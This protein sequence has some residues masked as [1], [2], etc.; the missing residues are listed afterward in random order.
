MKPAIFSRALSAITVLLFSVVTCF[1]QDNPG[2]PLMGKWTKSMNGASASFVISSD[3]EWEVE[4]TGDD[5][6][7]VWGSYAIAGNKITFTD[8]GGQY[9]SDQPGVYE[10]KVDDA[11]LIFSIVDDPVNGRSMLVE[12]TWTKA[13]DEE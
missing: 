8:E 12:G 4:F 9:S 10:Y 1:G 6:L 13:G 11:S 2:D 5:E 3:T 7:D